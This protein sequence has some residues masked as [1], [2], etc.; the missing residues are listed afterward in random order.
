MGLLL[1]REYKGDLVRNKYMSISLDELN[2]FIFSNYWIKKFLSDRLI[3][4]SK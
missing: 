4:Y 2:E 1:F 3:I